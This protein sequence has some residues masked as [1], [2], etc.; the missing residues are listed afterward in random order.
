MMT[1]KLTSI[2]MIAFVLMFSLAIVS[3]SITSPSTITLSA[4]QN[5]VDFTVADDVDVDTDDITV[6]SSA[7]ISDGTNVINIA[8]TGTLTVSDDDTTGETITAT[9]ASVPADFEAGVHSKT[10]TLTEGAS[11][12]TVKVEYVSAFCEVGAINDSDLDLT[13]EVNNKGSGEDDEWVLL[14][15]VQVEVEIDNG[16]DVDLDDVVIELGLIDEEGNNVADDLE[17]ISDDEEEKEI[18]DVDEGKDEKHEFEFKVSNDLDDGNYFLMVKAYPE[19]EEEDTCI[20]YFEDFYLP[21][22]IEREGEDDRQIVFED[23]M[24]DPEVVPCGQE[25]TITATA[26]NIGEMGDQDAVKIK[27]Y[28]SDL[29]VDEERVIEDFDADDEVNVEFTLIVPKNLTE[30]DYTLKLY[31]RYDYDEDD[32]E[33]D[34]DDLTYDD[35]YFDEQSEVEKITI[36]THGKCQGSLVTDVDIDAEL[37][38]DTPRA[39]IGRQVVIEVTL[40]NT[41]NEDATYDVSV[42]GVSDWAEVADI[43]PEQVTVEA[44]ESETVSIYLDIDNDAEAGDEEFTI[45]AEVAGTEVEQKVL[46]TLEEGWAAGIITDNIKENWFIYLI[47]L[48]NIILVVAIIIVVAKM[49]GRKRTTA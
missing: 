15:R 8:F 34:N 6:P 49:V 41:G 42:S 18:G 38:E 40:E 12:K 24:V 20:D 4:S 13:V 7:Q 47:I 3:A 29:D 25:I 9:Y 21:I 1:K 23:V 32:D 39:V 27:L 30:G 19:G 5:S 46:L 10:I 36:T 16:M 11:T 37:S 33:D 31:S 48:V 45:T 35:Q 14:D 17:W 2:L 28:S 43:D 26:Y 44:G 22:S